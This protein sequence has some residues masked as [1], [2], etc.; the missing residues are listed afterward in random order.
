MVKNFIHLKKIKYLGVYL[1]ETL[2]GNSHCEELIKILN[3]ANGMLAKAKHFVPSKEIKKIYIL[4][5]SHHI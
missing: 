5:S 4:Q 1:D 3:R 2:S